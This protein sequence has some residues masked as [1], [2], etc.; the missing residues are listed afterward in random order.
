MVF[1]VDYE[2]VSEIGH[3]LA[4]K[5]TELHSLYFDVVDICKEIDEN[6][7]SEDSSVYI[8]QFI[9]FIENK[10]RENEKLNIAGRTLKDISSIYSEQDNKW[11]N[12][13]LRNDIVKGRIE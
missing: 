1:K 3:Y 12:D 10:M 2:K 13:L 4:E 5:T 11:L 8:Y 9:S 6:W 7:R